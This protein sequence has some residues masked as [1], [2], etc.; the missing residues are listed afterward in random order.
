VRKISKKIRVYNRRKKRYSKIIGDIYDLY[1]YDYFHGEGYDDYSF[2]TFKSSFL[3]KLKLMRKFYHGGGKLLDV[4]C[5]LGFFAK[6]VQDD[7]LD[8][9]GVDISEYAV[10]EGKKLLGN[11]MAVAN[12]EEELP[13]PNGFF[14][15]I[16]AWD[17]LEHLKHPDSFLKIASRA[18]KD[19]GLIFIRTL[20]YDC[21]T[22]RLM[23]ENWLQNEP[24]HVSYKITIGDLKKWL[25]NASLRELEIS[26]SVVALKPFPDRMKVIE[27]LLRFQIAL[28]FRGLKPLN[29]GDVLFCVARKIPSVS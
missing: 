18:L 6:L 21:L 10:S 12:I 29:L 25:A 17:V 5:A 3:G 28:I 23:R 4:G 27:K 11:K 7:G 8:A 9:Y 22:A 16:T 13:F 26:T 20:N 15:V 19:N 14:D 2:E 24:L 1:D